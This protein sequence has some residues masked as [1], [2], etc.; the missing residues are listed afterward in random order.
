MSCKTISCV[1][2]DARKANAVRNTL[3]EEISTKCPATI[4]RT[5]PNT[6][7]FLDE[8]SAAKLIN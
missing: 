3:Y 8:A 5:H 7:L 2:P 4:L 1:V 6:K